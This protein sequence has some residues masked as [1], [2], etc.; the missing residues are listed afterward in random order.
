MKELHPDKS[1][2]FSDHWFHRFRHRRNMALCVKTHTAQCA[3]DELHQAITKFHAE[4]R[5]QRT[6]GVFSDAEIANMD[7]TPSWTYNI[8]GANEIWTASAAPGLDKRQCTTV[9]LT[10]FANGVA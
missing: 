9:W 1:F 3:P 5:W 4:L 8:T 7:Q 2:Q 10:V 6:R